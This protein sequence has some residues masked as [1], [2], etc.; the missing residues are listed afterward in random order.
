MNTE[1]TCLAHDFLGYDDLNSVPFGH[2]LHKLPPKA[3]INEH[4]FDL[5]QQRVVG[6]FCPPGQR[7]LPVM[8]VGGQHLRGD[9]GPGGVDEKK[10][11]TALD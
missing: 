2:F 7:T 3:P 11:L 6:Q 5:P 9:G 10:A 4:P 1:F 8:G